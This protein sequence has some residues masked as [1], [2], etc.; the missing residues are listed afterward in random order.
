MMRTRRRRALHSSSAG[1]KTHRAE[2]TM[3]TKAGIEITRLKDIPWEARIN[4][5]NWPNRAGMYF[6]D[7]ETKLCIRLIDYPFGSVEPRHVHAGMHATTVLKNRA[8][9]DGLTLHP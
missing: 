9:V 2:K 1:G 6:N 5:D 7:D 4:V 8:I 3:T